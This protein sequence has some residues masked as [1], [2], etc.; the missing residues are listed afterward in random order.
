MGP[1]ST[2]PSASPTC[3]TGAYATGDLIGGKLTFSGAF[4]NAGASGIL[5]SLVLATKA[6]QTDKNLELVIFDQ[7]PTGTTFTDQAA[8]DPADA[9]LTKI[10]CRILLDGTDDYSAF[11]DNAIYSKA[12]LGIVVRAEPDIAGVSGNLYGA[13]VARSDPTFAA[14]ADVTITLHILQDG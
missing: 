11:S 8:F 5:H 2:T 1:R 13:L 12:G 14:A 10:L 9:D 7:D 3:D 4:V 6:P